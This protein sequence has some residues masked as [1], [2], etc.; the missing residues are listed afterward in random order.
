MIV[1]DI[2]RNLNTIET[3]KL[4]FAGAAKAN[5]EFLMETNKQLEKDIDVRR[6]QIDLLQAENQIL[7]FTHSHLKEL[8]AAIYGEIQALGDTKR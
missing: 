7:S 3:T 5:T 4:A 8:Q 2:K 1:T 6:Q